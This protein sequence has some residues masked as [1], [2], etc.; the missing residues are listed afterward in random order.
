MTDTTTPL[1]TYFERLSSTDRS[2][3]RDRMER[4]RDQIEA[5]GFELALAEGADGF[6]AAVLVVDAEQTR[7]GFLE[8]TGAVT[9]IGGDA[10]GIGGL[11][12]A[13]LQSPTD[14]LDQAVDGLENAEVE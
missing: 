13:V 3:L 1:A 9:W 14:A 6:F 10:S 4:Y 2:R 7:Y 11:S 12:S 5:Q 8:E